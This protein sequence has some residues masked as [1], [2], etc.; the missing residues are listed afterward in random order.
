MWAGMIHLVFG[1]AVI[2]LG[3]GVLF[4]WLFSVPKRKAVSVMILANYTSAW[5]GGLFIRSAIVSALPMD[6]NNAWKWFWVM[7]FVT[8]CLT[9]IL[10]WPF[11]A[12]CLRGKKRWLKQSV[13]ASLVVQSASY[14]LLFG[15]YWMASGTSLYTQMNIV[16][17]ADLSLPES[18]LVYFIAPSDGNVYV[19]RLSG[20]GERKI[21]ELHST[22]KNDRLFVRSSTSDSSLWD[23]VARL[24]T[25]DRSDPRFVS[26]L[27]N[28]MVWA[29]PDWR[30]THTDPPQYAGTWFSFGEAPPLGSAT[31]SQWQF[32][33][34]FWSA[35]G[36]SAVNTNTQERLHFAYETP[37]GAWIVRN[38]VHL[39]SDKALF[40]LGDDQICALD[41]VN[42][43]VALLWH[44]RG[45]V[46]IIEP[47]ISNKPE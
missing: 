46:A 35:G 38:A 20:G 42:R 3:E 45:P 33:A 14:M 32:W 41:P 39:P 22:H 8:Y 2:G 26:V 18:V 37:F 27:T 17:P 10:E 23:L 6:L 5:I 30:S 15:W 16:A 24:D 44:G 34:G 12:W 28:M 21:Y 47:P 19:R 7:V 4:A 43:Q 13:W 9:L 29:A 36:F 40:Q 31:N 1:N 25:K 11:I